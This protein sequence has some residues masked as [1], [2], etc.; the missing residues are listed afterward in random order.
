LSPDPVS[1]RV[2]WSAFGS[3]VQVEFFFREDEQE[4][5]IVRELMSLFVDTTW[6]QM[7]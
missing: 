2:L 3:D 5:G 7:M 1:D 6:D 4:G